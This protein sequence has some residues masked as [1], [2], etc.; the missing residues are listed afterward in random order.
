MLAS[1]APETLFIRRLNA[2]ESAPPPEG[3]RRVSEPAIARLTPCPRFSP[4]SP[5]PYRHTKGR[6]RSEGCR[7]HHASCQRP[8]VEPLHHRIAVL[9]GGI[10]AATEADLPEIYS[11]WYETEIDGVTNAPPPGH[12]PWLRHMLQTCR[13]VVAADGAGRPIGFAGAPQTERPYRSDRVLCATVQPVR[14]RGERSPRCCTAHWRT[15][16]HLRLNGSAR[17]GQLRPAGHHLRPFA[18]NYE[19]A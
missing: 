8:V 1:G 4:S 10:R 5:S 2:A 3:V 7:G 15:A 11:I 12:D 6:G 13:V 9:V 16:D 17:G 18:L 14:R 19:V